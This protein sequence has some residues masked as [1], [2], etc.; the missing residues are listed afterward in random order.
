MDSSDAFIAW[1][2]IGLFKSDTSLVTIRGSVIKNNTTNAWANGLISLVV[3]QN[4]WGTTNAA[5][6]ASRLSGNVNTAGSLNQE[7]LLT[8]ALGTMDGASQVGNRQVQLKLAC[9]TAESMRISENSIFTG[10]FFEPYASSKSFTLSQGAGQKTVFVQYRSVTGLTNTPVALQIRYVTVGP[11]IAS[12]SLAEGQVLSRPINVTGNATAVLGVTQTELYMDDVLVDRD[13]GGIFQT[14][15]DVRTVSAG[16]HRIK[17]LAR[18]SSANIA[19]VEANVIVALQPPAA[20]LITIPA[21]DLITSNSS[22]AISGTAEPNVSIRLTRNNYVVATADVASDGTYRVDKMLLDEGRND[23]VAIAFDDVGSARSAIR[24]VVLDRGAPTAPILSKPTYRVGGGL[25]LLWSFDANGERPTRYQVYW[26][27]KPFTQTSQASGHSIVLDS[28]TYTVQG[29]ADGTYFFGVIGLDEA[30]NKSDLSVLVSYAFD[31]TPPTLRLAFD[32]TSP[33][34]PGPVKVSVI[35]NEPLGVT[36]S[37]TATLF[38]A[39]W[40]V[41]VFSH[42]YGFKCL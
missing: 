2:T 4:W 35:S 38:G 6:I 9:R 16:I 13:N 29:L 41:A 11:V 12:F 25:D 40:P 1:N 14:L 17:F 26:S 10:V 28:T 37:L 22:L 23:I 27:N 34:G 7:P 5:D 36:P 42:Q 15:W 18:D 39:N 30:G 3:T 31:A 32:K 8:P 20:P 19:T 21:S 24:S 33:V